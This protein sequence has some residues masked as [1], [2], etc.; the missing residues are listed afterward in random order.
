MYYT[1]RELLLFS[2]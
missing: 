1:P 2:I